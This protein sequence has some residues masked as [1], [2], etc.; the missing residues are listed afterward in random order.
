[1][2]SGKCN[3]NFHFLLGQCPWLALLIWIGAINSDS[4]F[5][6]LGIL[7]TRGYFQICVFY[8]LYRLPVTKFD[9]ECLLEAAHRQ[10]VLSDPD[11]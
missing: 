6:F 4:F 10:V 1:V 9:P 7:R 5:F 11:K 8:L 3:D 2:F